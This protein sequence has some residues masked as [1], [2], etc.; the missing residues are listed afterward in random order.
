MI[1]GGKRAADLIKRPGHRSSHLI[2]LEAEKSDVVIQVL[3]NAPVTREPV[4]S[5]RTCHLSSVAIPSRQIGLKEALVPYVV[6]AVSEIQ[7]RPKERLPIPVE[8]GVCGVRPFLGLRLMLKLGSENREL[9]LQLSLLMG[10]LLRCLS[11]PLIT[12]RG[13]FG[14]KQR[15]N[16]GCHCADDRD[17]YRRSHTLKRTGRTS[18][19]SSQHSSAVRVRSDWSDV[20]QNRR[21]AAIRRQ[22]VV[23][24][25][26][27]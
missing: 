19:Q 6:E 15:P 7:C 3:N 13:E 23:I 16:E 20:S 8:F 10:R 25:V 27:P 4:E 22:Y 14:A 26:A 18:C 21:P 9:F 17:N 1:V 12:G 5:A 24:I 2:F 11:G